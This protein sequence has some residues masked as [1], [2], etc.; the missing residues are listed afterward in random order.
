MAIGHVL[1]ILFHF[2]YTDLRLPLY[3]FAARLRV[4]WLC[5]VNEDNEYKKQGFGGIAMGLLRDIARSISMLMIDFYD[6]DD[7]IMDA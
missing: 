3:S 2:M 7:N 1:K 4:L 5:D 6:P